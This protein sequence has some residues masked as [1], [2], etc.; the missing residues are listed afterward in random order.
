MALVCL[1]VSLMPQRHLIVSVTSSYLASYLRKIFHQLLLDCFSHGIRIKNSQFSGIKLLLNFS[2]SNGV[3]QGGV[4][5]PIL[6]IVYIDELLTRLESQAV[7]CYW[8]HYFI[9][10]VEYADDI[11]LLA[12]SASTLRMMLINCCQFANDYNLLFNPGKTQLSLPCSSPSPSTSPT[13]LFANQTLKLG[14][15]ACHLDHIT[16]VDLSDADDILRVQTNMCR[17]TNCLL[18]LYGLALWRLSSNLQSLEVTFNN[19]CWEKFGSFLDIVILASF[20]ALAVFKAFI[21]LLSVVH[22]SCVK[23]Q[24]PQEF[25]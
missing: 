7:G 11:V 1:D 18:S 2:V 3:R 4:L 15:S 25:L 8:S 5:S 9:W 12:P 19:I 23:K 6:F 22:V 16:C 24:E 13:F 10:A 17:R 14:D 21:M 20:T